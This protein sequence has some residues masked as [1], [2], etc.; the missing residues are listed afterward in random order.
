MPVLNIGR[1]RVDLTVDALVPGKVEIDY[2]SIV[3]VEANKTYEPEPDLQEMPP[4]GDIFFSNGED[5]LGINAEVGRYYDTI[6]LFSF[7]LTRRNEVIRAYRCYDI[8]PDAKYIDNPE[9]RW[10]QQ[11]Y[12]DMFSKEREA[13]N[14]IHKLPFE[15]QSTLLRSLAARCDIDQQRRKVMLETQARAK[16]Q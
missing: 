10:E 4:D 2:G 9:L 5:V 1:F 13:T 14:I 11:T 7:K 3:D 16:K 12:D 8:G 15:R 6:I